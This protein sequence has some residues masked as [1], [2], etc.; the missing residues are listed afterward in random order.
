VDRD[1]NVLQCSYHGW[2]FDSSGS[3]TRIP[4]ATEEIQVKAIASKRSCV[5][6][7]PI[8]VEKNVL[9]IWPW[10]E[11]VLSV[12]GNPMAHPE[13][14]M[15]MVVDNPTT[16]TRDLPYGWASLVE[17]LVDPSHVPF[18]HHGMQGKR[19]DAIAINMTKPVDK[20]EEG[21]SFEWEDRTMG[22]M[23]G[24]GGQFRAP[25]IIDYDASFKSENPRP[26][27]LSALSIPTKSGWSRAIVI[28]S[29]IKDDKKVNEEVGE[30][31]EKF[32][33]IRA[34]FSKLPVWMLHQLSNRFLDSD[35]A[36][37]HFQERERERRPAYFMPTQA[38]RC[39]EALLKWIPKYT[40][41]LEP[42]PPALPRSQ[43]F[44][45]WTQHTSHCK[46]CQT[47]LRTIKKWRRS[48]YAV[49]AIS[50][51]GFHLRIAK[52]S[53]LLCFGMLRLIHKLEKGFREGEF[54]HYEN[55]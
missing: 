21:F 11:D 18:A 12:A 24:G 39:I 53:T 19:T 22:M 42:L 14:M 31:K 44:D 43:M 51:F 49:L 7:Y 32:S 23:R 34:I 15:E 20:G 30:K 36:F 27:K 46:H 26:F 5:A 38:D 25:F 29:T 41:I 48:A 2:E 6:A 16:Y 17:N 10:K 52:L 4:Q 9:W 28:G 37:L 33:L 3:C 54:K 45:R 13:G 1:A 40:D 55:H 8:Y 47:G 35:L 50:V